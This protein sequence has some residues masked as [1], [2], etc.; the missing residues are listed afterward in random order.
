MML[1]RH[2]ADRTTDS[3][4]SLLCLVNDAVNVLPCATCAYLNG[5]LPD[6][7][8]LSRTTLGFRQPPDY[9]SGGRRFESLGASR[10]AGRV[11]P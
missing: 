9:G 1:Y 3:C 8:C 4:S 2:S 6:L 11:I 10:W 5:Q 7:R